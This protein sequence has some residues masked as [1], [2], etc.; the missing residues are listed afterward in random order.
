MKRK[1]ETHHC[2]ADGVVD[3]ETLDV[4]CM[5]GKDVSVHPIARWRCRAGIGLGAA[6]AAHMERVAW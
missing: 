5:H 2:R 6:V 4:K 1:V 3:I